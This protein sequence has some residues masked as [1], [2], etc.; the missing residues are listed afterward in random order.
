MALPHTATW[1]CEIINDPGEM[2][3]VSKNDSQLT[4]EHIAT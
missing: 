3:P 2:L 4:T 1:E